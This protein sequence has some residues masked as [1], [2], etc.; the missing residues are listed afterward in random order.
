MER[1]PKTPLTDDHTQLHDTNVVRRYFAKF[2]QITGHLGRVAVELETEGKLTRTESRIIG[3][4]VQRLQATF[5]A[6]SYKYLMTG[7][8]DGPLPGNLTF[9]RHESGF[10]IAQELLVMAN[11]A[12]QAR[13]HLAALA[14]EPELKD[15]MIRQIVGELTI[16]TKLQFSLSQRLYYESLAA[17][18]QFWARNDPDVQWLGEKLGRKVWLL[19]WA[20][21]DTQTNLPVIYLMNVEDSSK[22]SLPRDDRRWPQVQAHLMAQSLNGLKL[23]TIAKGFDDD[24]DD[25]HPKRLRRIHI[26]PMYSHSFTE[27]SGPISEVL[28]DARAEA[29]QDW[30]LVWTIEDLLAEREETVKTG[31][32]ST[33]ERQIFAASPFSGQGLAD[34]GATSLERMIVLPERPYQAL[35]EK[36]PPGFAAV[37]KFVVG[38][39]GRIISQK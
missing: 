13:R 35:A 11:D 29:G 34:H 33:A 21:Y 24:F 23:L 3:G 7:R 32:F 39:G 28:S 26:G 2:D 9:D 14:T 8:V 27:Q 38:A 25:L 10:P 37:R 22:N 4:Y 30:A 18:P 1:G 6:L 5:R 36:N 20:V 31:W 17:E 15:A 12:L 19:H 16:P